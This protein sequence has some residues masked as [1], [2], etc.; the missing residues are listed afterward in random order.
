MDNKS[1]QSFLVERIKTGELFSA[2]SISRSNLSPASDAH[3]FEEVSILC[4]LNHSHVEKCIGFY[5]EPHQCLF[6]TDRIITPGKDFLEDLL[7]KTSAY[8]E[9]DVRNV[10]ITMLHTIKYCHNNSIAHLNLMP[11]VMQ[12]KVSK[13]VLS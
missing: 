12:F 7:V 11:D 5:E 4:S 9:T 13:L 1:S 2:K 3:V 6:V 10:F 8:S